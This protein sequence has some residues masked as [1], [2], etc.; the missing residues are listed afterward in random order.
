M[1]KG[2]K[3]TEEAKKKIAIA[4]IGRIASEE[5]RKNMSE[6]QKGNKKSKETIEKILATKK[7][8]GNEGM[9][10]KHHTKETRH[11]ISKAN[12]GKKRSE[13]ARLNM[14][15][16]LN[17]NTQIKIICDYC[18]KEFI[19]YPSNYRRFCSKECVDKDKIGKKQS[20]ESVKKRADANRGKKRSEEVCKKW[21]GENNPFYGKKQSPE[22]TERLKQINKGNKY[23]LG[24]HHTEEVKQRIREMNLGKKLLEETKRKIGDKSRGRIQSLETIEKRV[25]KLRGRKFSEEHCAKLSL[26]RKGKPA[27]NKGLT[28]YTNPNFAISEENKLKTSMRMLGHSTSEITRH[29]ISVANTGRKNTEETKA[30]I[31]KAQIGKIQSKESN[32]KR[33]ISHKKNWTDPEYIKKM[34]ENPNQFFNTE[35]EREMK[36]IL[37]KLN[38]KYEHNK[39]RAN[40]PHAYLTD[41]Y[42]PDYNLIIETDGLLF[43]A[44]PSRFKPDDIVPLIKMTAREKWEEDAIRTKELRD[45]G[46]KVLRFWENEISEEIVKK[47]LQEVN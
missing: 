1:I 5:A 18:K 4:G 45:V 33:S 19:D 24:K 43:H 2:S 7:E 16:A 25:A 44:H 13:E 42:L 17:K 26:I 41:F 30:K 34:T 10:G 20:P 23:H 38:I 6:A 35:P 36:K 21:R 32:Q 37:D 22:M 14:S 47:R 29:R 31:S 12:K 40:I 3:Q 15:K 39:I 11:K 9:S 28:K 8:R 27:W 46:Y